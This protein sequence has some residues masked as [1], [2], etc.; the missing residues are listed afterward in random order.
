[1]NLRGA[2]EGIRRNR[3]QGEVNLLAGRVRQLPQC[4]P[5]KTRDEIL[6][7]IDAEIARLT[8]ARDALTGKRKTRR[9]TSRVWSAAQRARQARAMKAAWAAKEDGALALQCA[10]KGGNYRWN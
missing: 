4:Q 7:H 5:V 10:D 3:L 8:A 9:R 1:M 2:S 6:T